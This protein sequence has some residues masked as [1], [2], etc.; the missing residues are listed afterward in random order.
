[1]DLIDADGL[2][3]NEAIQAVGQPCMDKTNVKLI[4]NNRS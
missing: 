3:N 2:L 4:S 1:V